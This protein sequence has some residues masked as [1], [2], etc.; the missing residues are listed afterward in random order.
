MNI[1]IRTIPEF[2]DRCGA[3]GT[4]EKLLELASDRTYILGICRSGGGGETFDYSVAVPCK[5]DAAAP[6]GFRRSTVPGGTW[7]VFP[8]LGPMPGAIQDLW[9][10]VVSEFFP[11]S[12]WKPTLEMDIEAYTDGNTSS[13][14]YASEIWVPVRRK[15]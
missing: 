6:E 2:W 14:D 3:D 10:R 1:S 4:L 15:D 11:T 5:A 13:E 7:A 12:G 9:R 8:C